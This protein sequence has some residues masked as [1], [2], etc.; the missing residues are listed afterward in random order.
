MTHKTETHRA[1][2]MASTHSPMSRL[3]K[4][5]VNLSLFHPSYHGEVRPTREGDFY[6]LRV[7]IDSPSCSQV[8]SSLSHHQLLKPN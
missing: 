7:S 6:S 2:E 4:N 3:S 5:P 8:F 1:V